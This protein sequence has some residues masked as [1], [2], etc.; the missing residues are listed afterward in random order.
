MWL[1]SCSSKWILTIEK[2]SWHEVANI[3]AD[4]LR[5][6]FQIGLRILESAWAVITAHNV[7]ETIRSG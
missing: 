5:T 3:L 7:T 1:D 4:S 6:D 2:K